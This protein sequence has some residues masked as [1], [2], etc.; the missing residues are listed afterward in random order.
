VRLPR[1]EGRPLTQARALRGK[2]TLARRQG[3]DLRRLRVRRPG[4]RGFS[5]RVVATTAQQ[6]AITVKRRYKACG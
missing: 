5:L 3:A 2:R 6:D 4:R 1:V